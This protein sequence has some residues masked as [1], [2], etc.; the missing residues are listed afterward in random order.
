MTAF[1][2]SQRRTKFDLEEEV[3]RRERHEFPELEVEIHQTAHG[4]EITP[5]NYD[6]SSLE[7]NKFCDPVGS[8]RLYY[9]IMIRTEQDEFPFTARLIPS[10]H[11]STP[12]DAIRRAVEGYSD[13]Q[14][15][16]GLALGTLT[17]AK[18]EMSLQKGK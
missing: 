15:G 6:F 4:V 18:V 9:L 10:P 2:K 5:L 12:W 3:E 7:E 11:Y 14:N 17:R 1:E 16:A 8:T 13:L